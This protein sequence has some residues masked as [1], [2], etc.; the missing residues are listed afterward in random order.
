LQDEIKTAVHTV[1]NYL[2]KSVSQKCNDFV[3]EYADMVI[4]LLAQT[5][6]PKQVCQELG[7]CNQ[8]VVVN[9]EEKCTFCLVLVEAMDKLLED[10]SVEKDVANIL[11]R[12]CSLVPQSKKQQV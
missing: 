6:E 10:G 9:A 1:C 4:S 5:L 8:A 7:L 3:N 12:V 11:D 2:P